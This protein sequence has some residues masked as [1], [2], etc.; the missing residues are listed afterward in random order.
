MGNGWKQ[1]D[2]PHSEKTET[3]QWKISGDVL[4][5]IYDV[6]HNMQLLVVIPMKIIC[7][8]IGITS[9]NVLT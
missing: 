8:F 1:V 2:I 9:S 3:L 5:S 6:H 7:L 4:H